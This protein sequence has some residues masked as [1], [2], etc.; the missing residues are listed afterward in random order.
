MDGYYW[1][2]SIVSSTD[3]YHLYMHTTRLIKAN[4]GNKRLG[5]ALRCV[6][7]LRFFLPT[8]S[9]G[10]RSYPLSYVY[11]GRYYWDTGRLYFQAV[12][13]LYWS[14]SIVSSALSYRLYM[15]STRLIK[16]DSSNKRDG[17]A[18]RCVTR[19]LSC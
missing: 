11:A 5:F 16:A 1:S 13:G 15:Y 8:G 17:Y 3:S 6:M 14:S 2:S 19:N 18:L 4:S 9:L 12:S 10:A 7:A